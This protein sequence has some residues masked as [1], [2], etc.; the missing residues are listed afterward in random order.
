VPEERVTRGQRRALGVLA[1]AAFLTFCWIAM[2]VG[3]GLFLGCL[4]AFTIE[5]LHHRL[6][7]KLGRPTLAAVL[8]SLGCTLA[9]AGTIAALGYALASQSAAVVNYLGDATQSSFGP[10]SRLLRRAHLD[11]GDIGA[12]IREGAA[13]ALGRA[14]SAVATIASVGLQALLTLLFIA[15][16]TFFV[17]LHWRT[18]TNRVERMLPLHPMHT[19]R[20]FREARS[21]GRGILLGTLV[22][23]VAQ[24]AV[25]A[26][27]YRLFG[28][29]HALL[30][31]A[32][33]AIASLVPAVG[34]LL[35]WGPIAVYLIVSGRLGAGIGLIVYCALAVIGVCDFLVRPLLVGRA[36]KGVPSLIT[37][38]AIFGGIE[39]FGVVGLVLGPVLVSI[40]LAVLRTWEGVTQAD[41]T[42]VR[43]SR[44][45][46]PARPSRPSWSPEERISH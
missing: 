32:L 12:R 38:I 37:F 31:G 42:V 17:L 45:S 25:A 1:I 24:G 19:R 15:L 22:T 5:P 4:L 8:C 33:T 44:P 9:I 6:S 21:A 40:C 18:L 3:M 14:A 39:V 46:A 10:I 27:G 34:T 23:G 7:A 30:L 41:D 13:N 26:L 29:E 11:P 43:I 2:P 16:S 35:V 28:V 20:L 36:E